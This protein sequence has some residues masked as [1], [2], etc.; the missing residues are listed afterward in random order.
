MPSTESVN[1]SLLE[2]SHAFV[3]EAVSKAV[4]AQDDVRQWQFAILA[5][6]QSAELGLKAALKAIHP[7]LV[8]ENVDKPARMVT[9]HAA[10]ARLENPLI[11]AITFSERDK[12]R[13]RRASKMRNQV[14]HADFE[15]TGEYA[16]ANFFELFG[17]V[18]DFQRR[19]LSSDLS[20]VIPPATF[21]ALVAIRKAI[22]EL[23]RRARDRIAEEGIDDEFVWACPNCGE[24]TFVIEDGADRCYA[25]SFT[26]V[27]IE[28]P[29]CSNLCFE[30]EIESF[31]DDID[32][33]YE[34]GRTVIHN[35][36]G[37]SAFDACSE[38]LP[39]IKEAIQDERE[40]DEMHRLEEQYHLRNA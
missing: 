9:L 23:V 37:Y 36:Y 18:S 21:D 34:E 6:V 38:C 25:C 33:D 12:N 13:I 2:N 3:N 39:K 16:A 1:L 22:E 15:L 30:S 35:S 4:A 14:T 26:E 5:L 28:C 24:D 10:L 7:I 27:V 40:R 29:Q 20:E 8:Y 31:I 17:F 32:T 11:G 19:H